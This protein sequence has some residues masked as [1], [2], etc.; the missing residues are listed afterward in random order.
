[1][2]S[3]EIV[4]DRLRIISNA[5][6][7][8]EENYKLKKMEQCAEKFRGKTELKLNLGCGRNTKQGWVNIDLVERE[9]KLDLIYDFSKGLPFE[10]NSCSYIYHEHV[11]EHLNWRNGKEFL[12]ECF[13]CLGQGGKLRLSYPD[14]KGFFTA[15][16]DNDT[17]YFRELIESLDDDFDYYNKVLQNPSQTKEER[18]SNPA[19]D[20][21]YSTSLKDRNLVKDRARKYK[22]PIEIIDYVSHQYGEHR[23]I[24]D[25]QL[26][27]DILKEIGFSEVVI[28]EYDESIDSSDIIRIKY[29]SF[30]EAIK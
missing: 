8:F 21:H 26:I 19:P 13:K 14:Y 3:L 1:M 9:N 5:I 22:N 30:I 18:K 24:Y 6:E 27:S 28:S 4:F 11:L 17:K 16:V 20:W 23:A 12:R 10:E 7:N 15:Y 25:N 2:L 29:S